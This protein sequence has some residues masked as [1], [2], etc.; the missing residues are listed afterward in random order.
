MMVL[1]KKQ[2]TVARD[3]KE[4]ELIARG[5]H[6][7]CVVPRGMFL[8]DRSNLIHRLGT[9]LELFS[10]FCLALFAGNSCI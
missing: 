10:F 8:F 1:Q 6:D 5:R 3:K 4:M 9:S 2:L 7:P